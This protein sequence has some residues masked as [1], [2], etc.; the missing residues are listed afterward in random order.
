MFWIDNIDFLDLGVLLG[1]A[2]VVRE[3]V[4]AVGDADVRVVLVRPFVRVH[5]RADPGHVS[6]EGQHQHV[7]HQSD[8]FAVVLGNPGWFLKGLREVDSVA[9]R[10][11]S[12]FDLSDGGQI[13]V[14]L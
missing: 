1:V 4:V 8:V 12:G 6:L 7:H 2:A 3:V 11:G 5:E 13:L 10:D 14:E 9:G